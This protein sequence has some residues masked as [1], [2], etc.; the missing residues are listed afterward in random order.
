M[1]YEDGFSAEVLSVGFLKFRESRLAS[2]VHEGE[3]SKSRVKCLG[4]NWA[5]DPNS[6]ITAAVDCPT[7]SLPTSLP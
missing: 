4:E 1:R 7:S 3:V 2:S 6:R 5:T